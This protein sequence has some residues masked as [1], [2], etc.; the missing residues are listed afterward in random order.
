MSA[1]THT[2]SHAPASGSVDVRL[3]WWAIALPAVAFAALLLLISAPGQAHAEAGGANIT[4][5]LELI[6]RNLPL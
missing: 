5:V 4:H 3:P 1:R 6:Q 2:R